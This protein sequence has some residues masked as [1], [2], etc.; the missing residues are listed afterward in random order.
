M[1]ILNFI[2][3][4][5][6]YCFEYDNDE[7]QYLPVAEVDIADGTR[8]SPELTANESDNQRSGRQHHPAV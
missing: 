3:S 1:K 4:G 7:L 2:A 8:M 6:P 5:L